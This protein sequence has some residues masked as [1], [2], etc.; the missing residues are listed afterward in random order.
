MVYAYLAFQMTYPMSFPSFCE[1]EP[2]K[3]EHLNKR[4]KEIVK[5]VYEFCRKEEREGIS[6]S[7]KKWLV[8]TDLMT[9]V[10]RRTIQRVLREIPESQEVEPPVKQP[11]RH[12][13]VLDDFDLCVIRRT[14]QTMYE[15]KKVQPTL[16][17]IRE[18]LVSKIEYSGS[19]TTLRKVL[20]SLGFTYKRCTQNRK[21]L[22]ERPDVVS[23]RIRF[24]RQIKTYREE[25][26]P[27]IYTDETYVHTSHPASKCWQSKDLGLKVPFGKGS[28]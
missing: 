25:G 27:I 14:I 20:K 17:N 9:G 26:R 11:P 8:R 10:N 19:I 3:S 21:V 6:V 1:M 28:D 22:M 2:K 16:S 13:I 12:Q 23:H 7:L 15:V 18:L 5:N 24:L 4:G